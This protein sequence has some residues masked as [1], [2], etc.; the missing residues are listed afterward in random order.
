MTRRSWARL[1]TGIIIVLIGIMLLLVTTDT[2]EGDILWAWI[3]GLFVL[4]G[5][6]ALVRSGFR[7][8]VGP[9]MLI[10][11]AG[12]FLLRTLNVIEAGVIGTYWPAFIVLFGILVIINRSRKRHRIEI[13][14]IST[15]ETTSVGVFG[16][17]R[18]RVSTDNFTNAE[19]VAIFGD[20]ELDLRDSTVSNPPAMIEATAVFGDVEI[21]LPAEWEIDIQVM[22]VFGDTVDRRPRSQ[23]HDPQGPTLILTGSAVFGDIEILD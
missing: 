9:V 3:P 20:S 15:S 14:G 19:V 10:A 21:R 18:R 23:E 2:V 17:D 1:T 11:I 5:V 4:L 16:S 13:S 22:S 7:N 8:I 6:W 12:A